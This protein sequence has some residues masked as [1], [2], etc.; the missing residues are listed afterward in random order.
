ML[1]SVIS[2]DIAKR[3]EGGGGGVCNLGFRTTFHFQLEEN[4]TA[5]NFSQAK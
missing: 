2:H 3:G 1:S 4:L 5:S